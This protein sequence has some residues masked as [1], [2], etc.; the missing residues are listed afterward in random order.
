MSLA[1]INTA[2]INQ[3]VITINKIIIH[4]YHDHIKTNQ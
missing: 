4:N 2:G 3:Q 1:A